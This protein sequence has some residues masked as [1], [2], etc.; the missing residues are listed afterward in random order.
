MRESAPIH[1]VIHLSES[2]LKQ[3]KSIIIVSLISPY[4]HNF[5]CLARST[6]IKMCLGNLGFESSE[7]VCCIIWMY[8]VY[9]T[10]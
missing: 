3:Y 9:F 8:S 7:A 5:V 2:S 6:T 10:I 1:L 4:T